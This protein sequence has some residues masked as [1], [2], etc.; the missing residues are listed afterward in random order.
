MQCRAELNNF[1]AGYGIL[2]LHID[3][4]NTVFRKSHS[5]PLL[6]RVS[7]KIHS[8]LDL[9]EYHMPILK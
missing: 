9:V 3:G 4:P 8:K 7:V 1:E 6:V 2:C 5:S